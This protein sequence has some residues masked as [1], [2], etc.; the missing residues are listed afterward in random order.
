MSKKHKMVCM[1]LNCI[2]HFLLLPSAITRY[3]SISA[4]ASL[5]AISIGV[6][7][8]TIGLKICVVTAEIEKHK[9]IINLLVPISQNG[10]KHS[11]NSSAICREI[12]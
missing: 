8:S 11:N 6:T 12:I 2:E 9:S 4:F 5:L 1:S 3:V 10:Q 7:S